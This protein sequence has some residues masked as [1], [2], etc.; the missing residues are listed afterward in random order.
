MEP[1][2]CYSSTNINKVQKEVPPWLVNKTNQTEVMNL[3]QNVR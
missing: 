1:S 3:Q 2:F